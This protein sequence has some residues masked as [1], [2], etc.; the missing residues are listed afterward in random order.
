M[1]SS[2]RCFLVSIDKVSAVVHDTCTTSVDQSLHSRLVA[3]LD[4]I[5]RPLHIDLGKHVF[6]TLSD[7]GD[8]R[9]GRMYYDSGFHFFED[10]SER[11]EICYVST[12]VGMVESC[13][14]RGRGEVK[15]GDLA[16]GVPSS[17]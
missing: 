11:R 12:K 15:Q 5:S 10:F 13:G 1:S 9:T 4:Y 3:S 16:V 8:W 6:I 14:G 2:E 7:G 17:N